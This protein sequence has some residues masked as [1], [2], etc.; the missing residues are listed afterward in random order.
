[1]ATKP[2]MG[3]KKQPVYTEAVNVPMSPK[4]KRALVRAAG[5]TPLSQYIRNILFPPKK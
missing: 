1:M 4:Q 3:T 5:T 2:K